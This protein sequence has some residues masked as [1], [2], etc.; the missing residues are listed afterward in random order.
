[1][2]ISS[3]TV[4]ELEQKYGAPV[5]VTLGY[6]MTESELDAV[7]RSQKS[8]RAHDVTLYIFIEAGIVVIRKPMYPPGAYRAPSGGIEPGE[9]FEQGALREAYEETGLAVSLQK[10][11]VRARVNF[12]HGEESIDWTTHVFTAFPIGG[13]L[14]P[15]DTAE[16]VEARLV[17]IHEL[18]GP[19]SRALRASGSTGLRYRSELNEIVMR[20]L[21][22]V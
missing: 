7:R 18:N 3:E 13:E 17:A 12:Y 1:M 4:R 6:E 14:G 9:P 10:Y 2:Y 19:I 16:I 5:E 22:L 11:I 8:G 15:V 21:A 20:E